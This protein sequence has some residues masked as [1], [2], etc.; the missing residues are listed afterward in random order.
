MKIS[1][2]ILPA[3]LMLVAC[4]PVGGSAKEQA[5]VEIEPVPDSEIPT[6]GTVHVVKRGRFVIAQTTLFCGVEAEVDENLRAMGIRGIGID[7]A[8]LGAALEKLGQTTQHSDG[9]YR[10]RILDGKYCTNDGKNVIYAGRVA[11]NRAGK[12]Y[13][14]TLVV[15]QGDALWQGVL[16][17]ADGKLHPEV[18][19]PGNDMPEIGTIDVEAERKRYLRKSTEQSI[20]LDVIEMSRQFT[21]DLTGSM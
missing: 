11:L 8:T 16:E 17:R 19:I 13:R 14:L 7:G 15:R 10:Q 6:D 1:P 21:A 2:L 9:S 4:G 12:P 3:A 20:G 5:V 18:F